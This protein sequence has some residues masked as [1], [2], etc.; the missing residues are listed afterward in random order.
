[1]EGDP[2]TFEQI[3]LAEG[4]TRERVRQIVLRAEARLRFFIERD[5]TDLVPVRSA[6]APN[7]ETET[8]R[9]PASI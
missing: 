3:G 5:L 2:R 9:G 7:A 6:V 8:E 1:M 4:I